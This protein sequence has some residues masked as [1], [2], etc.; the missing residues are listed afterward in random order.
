MRIFLIDSLTLSLLADFSIT[1]S[2]CESLLPEQPDNTNK[3]INNPKHLLKV[4]SSSP[5]SLVIPDD[6]F[7]ILACLI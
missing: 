6:F 4:F 3:I 7:Y 5:F 1:T 2:C